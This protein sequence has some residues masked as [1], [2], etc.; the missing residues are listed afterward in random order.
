M[1]ASTQV[2]SKLT[3]WM[4]FSK[5]FAVLNL[6]RAS[7]NFFSKSGTLSLSSAFVRVWI[8]VGKKSNFKWILTDIEN[9]QVPQSS[10]E[11]NDFTGT[12]LYRELYKIEFVKIK[13]YKLLTMLRSVKLVESVWFLYLESWRLLK[14][15]NVKFNS[16]GVRSL[17]QMYLKDFLSIQ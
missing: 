7:F 8:F 12:I 13:V 3:A 11:S 14:Y 5:F 17:L 4:P 9:R 2:S 15:F 1:I 6:I 10:C 16:E